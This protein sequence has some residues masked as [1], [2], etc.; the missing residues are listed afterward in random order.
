ME[1]IDNAARNDLSLNSLSEID[2]RLMKKREEL[3]KRQENY[4][5]NKKW[6]QFWL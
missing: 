1:N 3:E 5:K 2:K 6:W 4:K